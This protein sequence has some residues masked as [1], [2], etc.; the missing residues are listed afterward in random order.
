MAIA[1]NTGATVS[2]GTSNVSSQAITIPAGVNAGDVLLV[3]V[4]GFD[5]GS[6]TTETVQASSTGTAPVIIGT[7]QQVTF[8]ASFLNTALFYVVAASGEGG[9]V[10]TGSFVSGN[11]A[12]WA[13]ALGAWSGVSNGSPVDVSGAAT[14]S[15]NGSTITCPNE[16]TTAAGDWCVQLLGVALGGSA[17]TGGAGFTQRESVVD[18]TGGQ[19]A[20]IYDGNGSAGGAGASIGGANFANAGNNSWWVGWTVGL[21]PAVAPPAAAPQYLIRYRTSRLTETYRMTG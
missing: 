1:W 18:S 17:Y 12:S 8:S 6:G 4:T 16:T 19:G 13:I 5:F 2:N 20:V 3:V 9:K 21:T 10:I 15:G 14:A 11:L 7:T